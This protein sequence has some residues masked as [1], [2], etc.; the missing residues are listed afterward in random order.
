VPQG[1]VDVMEA[2]VVMRPSVREV[3]T[4][5]IQCVCIAY[6]YVYCSIY[7]INHFNLLSQNH[8]QI[9]CF[10]CNVCKRN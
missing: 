10:Y 8:M 3:R 6:S 5:Y 7:T 9:S 2:G 4:V 1:S